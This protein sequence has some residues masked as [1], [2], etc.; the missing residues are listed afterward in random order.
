MTRWLRA[1]GAGC[2]AHPLLV[3]TL[4]LATAGG[5]TVVSLT[6]GGHYTHS[7]TLPGT[8]VQAADAV[9]SAHLPA[10]ANESADVVVHAATPAAAESALARVVRAVNGLPHVVATPD[11]AVRWSADRR[12]ALLQV[13]YDVPRFALRHGALAALQRAV[14]TASGA[15]TY[16]GGS[17]ARN[18]AT[19]ST[20]LGEE[21]GIALAVLVLLFVFGSVIAALMPLATAAIAIVTGLAVVHLL[22]AAYAFNESAP[23]LATMMGLG[24]GVDY[25]LFI[26]TRHREGLRSGLPAPT[27]A[28]AAT[29]TS[30]SSVLWAGITVVAAICGLAFAGIPLVTSLGFAAAV[31]VAFS[32]AT[33]LTLLPALLSLTGHRIDRLRIPMP[34]LRHEQGR[35]GLDPSAPTMKGQP[36]PIGWERWARGIERHPLPFLIG[37]ALLLAVLA[38]PVGGMRLGAPDAS[39][40]DHRSQDYKGFVLTSRAFGIGANAPVT[41]VVA[42]SPTADRADVAARVRAAVLP[43]RN[44]AGVTAMTVSP[45]RAVGVLSLQPRSGPQDA[46]SQSLVARLRHR[47]LPPVERATGTTIYV[48]GFAAGRYDVAQR[49]LHR[50]PW[51]VGAVLAVSF[52]LLMVVFRSLLVPLKAVLLNLLSIAAALGVTV[53]VF[54]WGWLRTLVGLREAVPLED[55]VPMLMF[56]IVFGLSM[57]YEV[58]LLSRVREEWRIGGDSRGSV[59]RGLTSTARV[60]SAAASIMVCVFLAFTLSSDAVVKMIGLGLAVAVFLDATVIRLVLVPAT[61]SLLGDLNWW[62]PRWLDRLLPHVDVEG[63]VPVTPPAADPARSGAQETDAPMARPTA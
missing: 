31:V 55:V 54:T 34:H 30:G 41:L 38:I 7:S 20:G 42:L 18:A 45:D 3:V 33:S 37:P 14:R 11:P 24:V 22:A 16:V 5:V 56:A 53:A 4:W 50:L 47:L 10:A 35:L 1:L 6:V 23:Q 61:M 59:V 29:A 32:V 57:D 48:T 8:E 46:A 26:V 28:A 2:A 58:F 49:V 12:T 9:L 15:Q 60:I 25:A 40:A 36:R 43:D 39:S 51:F 62:L 27:A 19:P 21:V 63:A 44:V 13:G 52:L 17:L